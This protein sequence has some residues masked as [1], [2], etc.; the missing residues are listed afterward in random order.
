M[1]SKRKRTVT[2]TFT[3]PPTPQG[4]RVGLSLVCDFERD[5]K[6]WSPNQIKAF[7]RGVAEV[8]SSGALQ[9]G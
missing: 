9:K 6:G 3:P 7:M 4:I 5:F 1:A 2:R 8:S